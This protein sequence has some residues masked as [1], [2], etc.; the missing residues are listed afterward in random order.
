MMHF[1]FL[2]CSGI[3]K[4]AAIALFDRI[5]LNLYQRLNIIQC[6]FLNQKFQLLLIYEYKNKSPKLR[7]P[8]PFSVRSYID[9]QDFLVVGNVVMIG[10]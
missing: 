3:C 7:C 6:D 1:G 4:A 5:F 2:S 10:F 8:T 9:S